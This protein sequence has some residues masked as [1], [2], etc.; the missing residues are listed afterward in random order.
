MITADKIR[1]L[2]PEAHNIQPTTEETLLTLVQAEQKKYPIM[3][4]VS[5]ITRMLDTSDV[6]V[7]EKLKKGEIP[8]AKHIPGIGWRIT[9]DVFFT[10]LY[11][12]D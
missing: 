9:R 1:A 4:K 8:G 11:G 10:W 5:Q 7:Y 12:E 6:T 3:L 2:T